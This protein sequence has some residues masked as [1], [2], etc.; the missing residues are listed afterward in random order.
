MTNSLCIVCFALIAMAPLIGCKSDS[1]QENTSTKKVK[2]SPKAEKDTDLF[3]KHG[4]KLKEKL[5]EKLG[6]EEEGTED[7]DEEA[8]N[9]GASF[10]SRPKGLLASRTF[11]KQ[12]LAQACTEKMGSFPGKYDKKLLAEVCGSVDILP[13]CIS[14]NGQPIY[15][16]NRPSRREEGAER[17]LTFAVTHGDEVASGAVARSWANRLSRISPRNEWRVIPV[18]NPDGYDKKTRTNAAGVDVNRN[19]PSKDWDEFALK[20]WKEKK[21]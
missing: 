4:D 8:P 21:K 3:K 1:N 15:H 2:L 20:W 11:S 12:E 7:S 17:I 14:R 6:D 13:S 9:S 18:L 5:K 10:S 19:Y 16:Y